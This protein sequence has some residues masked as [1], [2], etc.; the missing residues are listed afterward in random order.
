MT[1]YVDYIW[2]TPRLPH[3]HTVVC[4][5]FSSIFR[6]CE[7]Q[8]LNS[9]CDCPLCNCRVSGRPLSGQYFLSTCSIPPVD[10]VRWQ[11]NYPPR[12]S[13]VILYL[14]HV[15]LQAKIFCF[16]S[17]RG[18]DPTRHLVSNS[19]ALCFRVEYLFF[20]MRNI[21]FLSN[22]YRLSTQLANVLCSVIW[23]RVYMF[24]AILISAIIYIQ[25]LSISTDFY[26]Q[27]L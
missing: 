23:F 6:I 11:P 12:P 22:Y 17:V 25:I 19:N 10:C 13:V 24:S 26:F 7:I 1:I 9:S 15:P 14:F 27:A 8:W 21:I 18:S 4:F 2:V 3:I 5:G 20:V 16:H